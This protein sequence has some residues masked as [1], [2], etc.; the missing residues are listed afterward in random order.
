MRPENMPYYRG[1]RVQKPSP[2]D[3]TAD[4]H[5]IQGILSELIVLE[6]RGHATLSNRPVRFEQLKSS[7]PDTG[8]NARTL[9]NS[10]FARYA[11]ETTIFNWAVF[12]F[13]NGHFSST[14]E[15]R[16]LP[17]NI[18]LGCDTT[19][20]GRSL[21]QEFAPGATVFS[22]GNDLL[23]HIRAS[24]EQTAI[25]GYLINSYR[26]QNSEVTAKFWK[27][28]LSIIAQIR[29][30]R[31]LSVIVTIVTKTMMAAALKNVH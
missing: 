19:E 2:E 25:S 28:Q 18:C 31:S 23:N 4:A 27:L 9:L 8:S 14:I 20:R 10:E 26:F 22:S 13:S 5:H 12:S 11:H 17:F 21:F 16:N 15:T 6:G 29:L 3:G 7:L 30:I 24:G 1:P